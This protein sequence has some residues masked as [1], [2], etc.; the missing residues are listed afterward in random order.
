MLGIFFGAKILEN[1]VL[2]SDVVAVVFVY[3]VIKVISNF[4]E[5]KK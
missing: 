2:K 3:V 5:E 4:F 1:M